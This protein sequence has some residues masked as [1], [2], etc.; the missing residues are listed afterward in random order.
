L[1][2]ECFAN[3][4][5]TADLLI[6]LH[7]RQAWEEH[8]LSAAGRMVLAVIEGAGQPLEPGVIAERLIIT[9]GSVTSLLDT[10]EKRRLVRRLPHPDDRR[11]LLVEITPEAEAIVDQL[12]PSLHARERDVMGAALSPDEQAELLSLLARV[13]AAATAAAAADA[14]APAVA[15][16]RKPARHR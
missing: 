7:N 16:R 14:P 4:V 13:Q 5:R 1:A 2:T 11:K 8:R 12:L 15:A 9:S 6:G 10:L 3:L